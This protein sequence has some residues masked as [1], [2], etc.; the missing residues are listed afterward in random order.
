M[1]QAT[2]TLAES[3]G[4]VYRARALETSRVVALKQV[5]ISAE[6]RQNGVPITALREI[7][8]LRSLKHNNI[9]NVIDVAVGEQAM[10]EVYMVMEYAEQ[11]GSPMPR[12]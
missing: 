3:Y 9:I 6:E 8:I 2:E 5:R 1:L 4:V 11:V 7:S 12:V 10:D